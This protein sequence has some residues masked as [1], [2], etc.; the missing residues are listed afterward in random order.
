MR[1]K[2]ILHFE[3]VQL[4][5]SLRT[6]DDVLPRQFFALFRGYDFSYF[7]SIGT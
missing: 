4:T 7:A 2:E 6:I 5:D 1:R 3:Y